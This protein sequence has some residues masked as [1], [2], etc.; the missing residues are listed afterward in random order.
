MEGQTY[1]VEKDCKI[2]GSQTVRWAVNPSQDI[3][4]QLDPI[5]IYGS[6]NADITCPDSLTNFINWAARAY[7]ARKYLL[8]VCDHGDGYLPDEELP[9][10]KGASTRG[11]V[12]D[13]GNSDKYF[14][15]KSLHRAI[16]AAD[17]RI[18]TLFMDACLMNCLEYQF[19]LQDVCDYVIAST[20]YAYSYNDTYNVLVE[21][22]A[23]PGANIEDKLTTFIKA[24]VESW[25]FLFDDGSMPFYTDMTLTRTANIPHLGQMLREF[26]YRLC[27]TYA[28]GTDAQRE[29][30][31]KCTASAI[32]V[33]LNRPYYDAIKYVRE[34]TIALPEVYDDDFANRM[35]DAFNNCIV[36]QFFSDYLTTHN[37]MVDYSVM[38][39]MQG[40]YAWVDWNTDEQS[41]EKTPSR[42]VVYTDDGKMLGYHLIPTEDPT[43][44]KLEPVDKTFSWPSTL[45]DTYEQLAFDR[46][47]GW[48]RWLRLNRQWPNLFCP[49]ELN[50]ELP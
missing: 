18:E 47:V 3:Y 36:S 37:F 23:R 29:V 28:N 44:Y 31:D 11:L 43:Y 10:T 2:F 16:A 39:G 7:P 46:A 45:A 34:L 19:E 14:T 12:Y 17:V 33:D 38:L 5:N 21:Q 20:H 9:E 27:D 22:L 48:S 1:F 24:F 13:D 40:S 32:R 4:D 15:A 42:M 8:I 25:D 50:Y 35:K 49:R 41:G 6:P 30:I 26:T